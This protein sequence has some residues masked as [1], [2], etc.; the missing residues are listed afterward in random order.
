MRLGLMLGYSGAQYKM[1]LDLVLEAERLGYDSVWT[2][3]AYGSD[4]VTPAAWVLARTTRLKAGTAIMQLAG[5]TPACS[6]MTAMTLDHLSAGRF[7]LG[8]GPSGPQ[9]VEGWHGERYGKPISRLKE[10]VSIVRQILARDEPVTHSGEHY[11][12]PYHGPGSTGLGKPLK[13]ILHGNPKLPIYTAAISPNGLK[14]A[15]EIADG[16]FPVWMNPTRYDLLRG[17]LEEGFALAGGGK[18]LAQ[19]DVAP[20]VRVALGED[21]DAS[22]RHIKEFLALYIGGMGARGKNFYND[23]ACRLGYEAEAVKIQDLYLAGHKAEAVAAVPDR[24]VDECSLVGDAARI[25][26]HLDPWREAVRRGEVG[27]IIF[28]VNSPEA[29][30]LLAEELL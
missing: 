15:G 26:D 22:R 19:F 3:E 5:R 17:P 6:A 25:R 28:T 13:S 2:A 7:M 1:P 9:V 18:S 21:L 11:Q 10:Y 16:V 20:F 4:A 23:Y 24:L 14:A 27:S 8:L 30:R 12:I 29:L